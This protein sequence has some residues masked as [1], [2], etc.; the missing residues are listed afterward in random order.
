MISRFSVC[1]SDSVSNMPKFPLLRIPRNCVL[2][3]Q[4]ESKILLLSKR[5]EIWQL[6]VRLLTKCHC[7]LSNLIRLN[8]LEAN[9]QWKLYKMIQP[10][11]DETS[12]RNGYNDKPS[13]LFAMSTNLGSVADRLINQFL[14]AEQM[15]RF[16]RGQILCIKSL[17]SVR[18]DFAGGLMYWNK[19]CKTQ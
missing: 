7:L 16:R 11:Q 3:E 2:C 18:C 15:C 9:W 8:N 14:D 4:S 5:F 1:Y 17:Q 6:G 10:L 12:F 19:R 13:I